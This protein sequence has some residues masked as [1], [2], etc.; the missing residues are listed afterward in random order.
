M[1]QRAC[2][3]KRVAAIR[4]GAPAVTNLGTTSDMSPGDSNISR[5]LQPAPRYLMETTNSLRENDEK[6]RHVQ[7]L[8]NTTP[9]AH[10]T[11]STD[12]RASVHGLGMQSFLASWLSD[13]WGVMNSVRY[14]EFHAITQRDGPLLRPLVACSRLV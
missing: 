8:E 7:V 3:G 6:T 5:R 9:R 2:R 13:K 4:R 1:F 12:K 10:P 14:V 11:V